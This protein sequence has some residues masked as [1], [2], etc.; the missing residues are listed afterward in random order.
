M[1]RNK[2][3]KYKFSDE[4]VAKDGVLS[5]EQILEQRAIDLSEKDSDLANLIREYHD[6][7]LFYEIVAFICIVYSIVYAFVMHGNAPE[8][9]GV[10]LLAGT[11]SDI[12]AIIFALLAYKDPD[13]G[14]LSKRTSLIVSV[15]N[16]VLLVAI[17]LI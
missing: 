3:K 16:A 1:A 11:V 5:R 6:G 8:A 9:V 15:V 2:M 7:L 12:T 17:Y 4:V 10:I 13:G 14:I